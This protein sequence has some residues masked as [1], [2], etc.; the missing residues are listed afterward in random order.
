MRRRHA[1]AEQRLERG[2]AGAGV[3][4]ED[5]T[6][7][8]ND[9]VDPLP[10]V[11]EDRDR[12]VEV[13]LALPVL[14][15]EQ[16]QGR[17]Q[18]VAPERDPV[19]RDL[20][21]LADRRRRIPSLDHIRHAR[22]VTDDPPVAARPVEDRGAQRDGRPGPA[23]RGQ[24]LP[25]IG[26]RDRVE[27]SV[28][29]EHVVRPADRLFGELD[30]VARAELLGLLDEHGRRLQPPGRDRIADV[31]G[32]VADDDHDARRPG[33]PH[34]LE[35]VPQERPSADR[36]QDLRGARLQAL[37]LAR[38]EHHGGERSGGSLG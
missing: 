6:G 15:I 16:R 24:Q 19:R 26:I 35:G 23:M 33:G 20:V 17:V 11:E 13:V 31:V 29:D 22:A 3:G 4:A 12:T 5:A 37:T 9:R 34:H 7:I 27:V 1:P 18:E 30:R 2:D 8:A 21:D 25:E 38:G 14:T 28:G 10:L 32:P 36:M